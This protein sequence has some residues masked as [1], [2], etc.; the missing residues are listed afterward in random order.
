LYGV[1]PASHRERVIIE[2]LPDEVLLEIFYFFQV[3]INEDKCEYSW[4][5]EK[6]VHVCR[7][8]R[9][10]IFASPNRLN[11][12]HFFTQNSPVRALLD[13]WPDFPLAI[14][15]EYL[16][17]GWDNLEDTFDN[18]LAALELRDRIRQIHVNIADPPESFWEHIATAMKGPFPALRYLSL[19]SSGVVA[20]LPDTFLNGSV[21]SLQYLYLNLEI[22]SFPS[23]PRL[24]LSTN[25]LTS[26]R[27]V[28]LSS[29]G[30]IPPETMATC[31]SALSKLQLLSISFTSP[32]PHPQQ[33]NQTPPPPTR[34]VLPALT[35]LEF[36]GTSEYLEALATRFDALRL[37]SSRIRF[38]HEPDLDFDIPQTIQFLGH[39]ERL[40]PY[41]VTLEF[42]LPL[43]A[44]IV[45][46]SSTMSCSESP[47]SHSWDIMCEEL[48]WQLASVAQIC[49]QILPSLSSV[50]SL[51]IDSR[52]WL[53]RNR[54]MDSAPWLQIFH[55]FPSVRSLSIGVVLEPFITAAFQGLTVESAAEVFPLLQRL[56]I[57]GP[58]S[59]ETAQQE[60]QPFLTAR[61]QSG[62]PVAVFRQES[63][64][65]KSKSVG[66]NLR[67]ERL[68]WKGPRMPV[69]LS[70]RS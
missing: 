9:Y 68:G 60:I 41:S 66:L 50:E 23:L 31:L 36:T 19:D 52:W 10:L 28:R 46:S 33:R 29:F 4:N 14:Q 70:V 40:R 67:T 20:S 62:H 51:S 3:A 27:L 69:T 1:G 61:Q 7:R 63:D 8:W 6:L 43:N 64:A 32:T 5:W 57:I 12:L 35:K 42:H 26:L 24:L 15:F 45:F 49:S 56:F 48:D 47:S 17:P 44:T 58:E 21:T 65:G 39:L 25:N 18:L 59:D 55:S 34:F 13:V 37:D 16:Q 38:F 54:N 30:F 22:T 11:L 2:S 53:R